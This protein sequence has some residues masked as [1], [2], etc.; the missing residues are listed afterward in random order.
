[1][2]R[3]FT[4]ALVMVVVSAGLSIAIAA[5][6]GEYYSYVGKVN[7]GED[8]YLYISVSGR[9]RSTQRQGSGG[10][11]DPSY[12][13]SKY[14]LADERTKAWMRIA[15]A[16]LITRMPVF[17]STDGC[18]DDGG[19]VLVGLQ[20][21]RDVSLTIPP[22][23]P[24][25]PREPRGVICRPQDQKCCDKLPDGTCVPGNCIPKDASCP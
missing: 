7:V 8:N 24:P 1:M 15:L 2:R 4:L 12:A 21:E 20:I 5:P 17:V 11:S 14:P 10:C 3:R 18:T 16:S 25:V 19:L 13:R 6:V 22:L 23:A 9:F